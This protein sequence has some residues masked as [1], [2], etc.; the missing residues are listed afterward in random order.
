MDKIGYCLPLWNHLRDFEALF[1]TSCTVI[2]YKVTLIQYCCYLL[3]QRADEIDEA[4]CG[5]MQSE[6]NQKLKYDSR[7][8]KVKKLWGPMGQVSMQVTFTS[9]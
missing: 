7:L 3:F 2:L 8:D 1:V 6:E 4:F 5:F 9:I